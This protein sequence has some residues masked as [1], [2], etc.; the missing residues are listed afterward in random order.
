MPTRWLGVAFAV[1]TGLMA[2]STSV[3]AERPND[4]AAACRALVDVDLVDTIV[5]NA[6]EVAAQDSTPAFCRVKGYV[7]PAINFELHLPVT[8]WNGKFYMSGCGA[9]CGRMEPYNLPQF[10]TGKNRNYAT[11][12]TDGG[13]WGKSPLD[14]RWVIGNPIASDDFSFR[15]IGETT[16]VGKALT[17]VYYGQNIKYSYFNGCS[18]GGRQGLVAATVYPDEYD[19]IISGAPN[20]DSM[21]MMAVF[22]SL[23]VANTDERKQPIFNPR[24]ITLLSDAVAKACGDETGLI[25]NPFS[26]RFDP[27][28]LQCPSGGNT[29]NCL[30]PAEV[31]VVTKWYAAPRLKTGEKLFPGSVPYGSEKLWG[32]ANQPEKPM[33][34]FNRSAF[35]ET[36][37][38]T[39]QPPRP[40]YT[41]EDI[42][43]ER[44]LPPL[45]AQGDASLTSPDLTKFRAHKGKLI[46]YHGFSDIVVPP[47]ST[48]DYYD[49][50]TKILGPNAA[51][52]MRLFMVPG[53]GHC[54][55]PPD[56]DSPGFT[57]TDYDLLTTLENWVERGAVPDKVIAT[58]HDKQ[59]KPVR[60]LPLCAYPASAQYAGSGPRADAANWRCVASQ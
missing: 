5:Q 39:S 21:G 49:K 23:L 1:A 41:G 44:D 12:M 45:K 37:R 19:G 28:S 60:T 25:I 6:V 27:K 20:V 54:R 34:E 4:T 11:I 14:G 29:T 42:D 32:S 52:T 31:G 17:R 53:M 35:A 8:G 36:V 51:D 59:G 40:T 7:R 26:C 15:S 58:K 46:L 2:D 13:H 10:V 33:F 38:T 56:S 22:A 57:S 9:N 47:A 24:K 48:A 55:N 30:T 50:V 3:A 43:L 18:N 16:R